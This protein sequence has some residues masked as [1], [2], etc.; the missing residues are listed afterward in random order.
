MLS[1]LLRLPSL[2]LLL[3]HPSIHRAVDLRLGFAPPPGSHTRHAPL[4]FL[5]RLPA[6][7][8]LPHPPQV[9]ILTCP[10]L[11]IPTPTSRPPT[12]PP[13]LHPP[14][15]PNVPRVICP[16]YPPLTSPTL[17]PI[18]LPPVRPTRTTPDVAH[19]LP[20][21]IETPPTSLTLQPP[22]LHSPCASSS[23]A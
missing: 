14:T 2:F 15:C 12:P 6:L 13:N 10:S 11:L 18:S 20:L 8:S 3:F 7:I 22:P 9:T 4:W 23:H 16:T 19:P 1:A 21:R 5:A 17:P